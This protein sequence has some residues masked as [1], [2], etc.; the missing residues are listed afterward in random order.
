MKR[1][2]GADQPAPALN[3]SLNSHSNDSLTFLGNWIATATRSIGESKNP[4]V[5]G[6]V[7]Q[8]VGA[9]CYGARGCANSAAFRMMERERR[10]Q[11]LKEQT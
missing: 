1:G 4:Y 11:W 10:C 3:R 9:S 8:G 5:Y 6:D 7:G 2:R